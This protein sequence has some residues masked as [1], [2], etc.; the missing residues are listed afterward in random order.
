MRELLPL[1]HVLSR[2]IFKC[3]AFRWFHINFMEYFYVPQLNRSNN[4][5]SVGLA[6]AALANFDSNIISAPLCDPLH[7]TNSPPQPSMLPSFHDQ[8]LVF[9]SRLS[10]QHSAMT[11]V[12]SLPYLNLPP[13]PPEAYVVFS[14]CGL[15]Q[16]HVPRV[17][18]CT[19]MGTQTVYLFIL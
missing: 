9:H 10:L 6:Q 17:H 16:L 1:M 7:I 15:I 13:L 18:A 4:R 19:C 12:V 2:R 8:L 11:F 3:V 14:A 5:L